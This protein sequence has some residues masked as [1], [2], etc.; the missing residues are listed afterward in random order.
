MFGGKTGTGVL[1]SG[2]WRSTGVPGWNWLSDCRT[3]ELDDYVSSGGGMKTLWQARQESFTAENA[4]SAEVI[5]GL[6]RAK[7]KETRR[8]FVEASRALT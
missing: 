6:L 5:S 8:H 1:G 3:A 7:H 4:E 2:R